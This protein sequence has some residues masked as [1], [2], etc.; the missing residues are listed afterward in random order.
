MK[1]LIVFNHPAPYKIR[2]FNELAKS[3]DLTVIFERGASKNRNPLFYQQNEIQFKCIFL[4]GINISD[5]NHFSFGV[6]RHLKKNKYDLIII[7]GYSTFSEMLALRY[8]HRNKIPYAMYVNG[9]VIR[10]DSK[11]KFK[12]KKSLVSGAKLYLSPSPEVNSY[13]VHYGA[14]AERIVNYPYSTIF[15][16]EIA[17]AVLSQIE[18][19]EI[20]KDHNFPGK[21]IF[22]SA[23]QFIER[24]NFMELLEIWKTQPNDRTLILIG[25]GEELANYTSYLK[26]N[27]LSNVIILPFMVTDDLFEIFRASDA[28]ILLSK[29]DIYGHV[30]NEAMSQGLPVISS[31][32]VVAA[33]H[34]ITND[35]N[36]FLVDYKNP[37]DVKKRIEDVIGKN[38]GDAP[39][40]T[41]RE[42][43]IE[44]MA[45]VH[46]RIFEEAIK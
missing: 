23:G 15:E 36:G 27:K 25:D 12:V 4:K 2:L 10:N 9:G 7:N 34:L 46:V 19:A 39:L 13:L 5:E 43:T 8:L 28:F 11:F 24:K 1:V 33:Q 31:D 22:V 40:K 32:R 30:I 26:E 18:K 14:Q 37:E 16:K 35:I 17:P 6:V 44:K 29:E 38:F 20:R 3:V 45:E 21:T 41:A 42:N